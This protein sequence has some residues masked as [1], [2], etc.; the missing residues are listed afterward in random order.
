MGIKNT[1]VRA[2]SDA[3]KP[4]CTL[5]ALLLAGCAVSPV[6]KVDYRAE[7]DTYRASERSGTCHLHQVAMTKKVVPINYGLPSE[8]GSGPSQEVRLKQFPFTGRSPEGGCAI[9]PDA[10]RTT[11]VS[12][13]PE[14][15]AA[16]KRW[17]KLHPQRS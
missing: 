10:P 12:V 2:R 15:V 9:E 5:A 13:C 17:M 14:C 4:L 11:E 7:Y 16:E 1:D 6:A 8:V 3:M